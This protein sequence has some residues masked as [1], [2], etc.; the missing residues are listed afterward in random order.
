MNDQSRV[1]QL[2]SG[3]TLIELLVTLAI[4][5]IVMIA[6]YSLFDSGQWFY[7]HGERKTKI[8]E[9]TRMALEQMERDIRMCG[10]GVPNGSQFDATTLWTP[11][12]FTSTGGKFFFRA[13]IDS[14]HSYVT[15]NLPYTE[16]TTIYVEEP[17]KVCPNPGFSEIILVQKDR[18]WQPLLCTSATTD[19][20]PA[21]NRITVST[22]APATAIESCDADECH[23]YTPE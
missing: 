8:Q 7:L 13:D 14:G 6:V 10:F 1:L 16:P 9:I 2:E 11:D 22:Y 20:T 21:N 15:V 3:F 18:K 5:M 4:F 17:D 19:P 12:I 23:I